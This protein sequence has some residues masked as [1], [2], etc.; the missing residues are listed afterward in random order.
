MKDKGGI[1][2]LC[3]MLKSKD[4]PDGCDP[5]GNPINCNTS[6]AAIAA[7]QNAVSVR[8]LLPLLD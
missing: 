2:L 7:L 1:E 4:R 8:M 5:V 6:A 3:G